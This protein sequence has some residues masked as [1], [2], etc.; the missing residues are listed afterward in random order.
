[1]PVFRDITLEYQDES[2]TLTPSNR[3]LRKIEGE[4]ISLTDVIARTSEGKPPISEISFICASLLTA[5][6]AP[7]VDEDAMYGE[8][9]Q[10]VVDNGGKV[11]SGMCQVIVDI[12]SPDEATI[13][14]SPAPQ[15]G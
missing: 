14:K 11:F 9:M 13:K 7:D 5:A 12:L 6:G 8:L 3:L 4:G 10:D 1:M 15:K 2:Y